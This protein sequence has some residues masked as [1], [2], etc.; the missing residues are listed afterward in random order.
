MLIASPRHRPEDLRLWDEFAACDLV[1]GRNPSVRK[2][3]CRSLIAIRKFAAAPCYASVS[4]GK[5]SVVLAHLVHRARVMWGYRVPLV[6]VRVEPIFNPDCLAVR[7]SF[8]S[9]H[10]VDYHEIRVECARDESGIH[11][12]GTL[13]RGFKEAV[14]RFGQRYL[15]GVR[16]DESGTRTVACRR[17][18]LTGTNTA[19]PLAWWSVADVFGWLARHDLPVHPAYA[20]LGAGRWERD[21]LRVS[22]LGGRRG[23]GIGRAEW[24]AEYY[25]DVLRRIEARGG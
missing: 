1:H 14:S 19:R 12:T 21:H 22:A 16:A 13:E 10:D 2:K 5:D 17:L 9:G 6:W 25:G 23:D 4:W 24:E 11:A 3:A 20:M 18:G 15:T 8:L 7:D